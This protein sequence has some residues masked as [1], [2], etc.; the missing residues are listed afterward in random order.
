MTNNQ[1]ILRCKTKAN[2]FFRIKERRTDGLH[3]L[4]SLFYPLE[5]PCDYLYISPAESQ[6]GLRI[7][8]SLPELEKENLLYAAYRIF[9]EKTGLQP[10]ILLHLEKNVPLGSGLGGAS[11][12]AA[13]FLQYL[14][15]RWDRYIEKRKLEINDL[16]LSLGSDVPFFLYNS[17]AWVSGVGENI[18]TTGIDLSGIFLLVVLP[19]IFISTAEAYKAWDQYAKKRKCLSDTERLLTR[20]GINNTKKKFATHIY[21]FNSFE[22]VVLPNYPELKPIKSELF[23]LGASGVVLSGSGSSLVALFKEKSMVEKAKDRL[24]EKGIRAFVNCL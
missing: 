7:T 15:E 9:V 16:A 8:S 23:Q 13:V 3:E 2:L 10:G 24:W 21:L 18:Q 4:E 1:V 17:P 19:D 22:K 5:N 11:S 6:T 12:N 14:W 20:E